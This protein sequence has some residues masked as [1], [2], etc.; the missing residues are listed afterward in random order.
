MGKKRPER[1]ARRAQQRA[2]RQLVRDREKLAGLVAGGSEERPIEVTSSAVIEGRVRGMPCP[3]CDGELRI[4]EHRSAGPGMR[5]VDV[6]CQSCGAPRTLWF[7]IVSD[8]PN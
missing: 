5:A 2:T 6:R 3:Q 4:R 7:R 1:T 8:D